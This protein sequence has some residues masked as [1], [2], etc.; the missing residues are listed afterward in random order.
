MTKAEIEL[1]E[2]T[3]ENVGQ[4]LRLSVADDQ[5]CFVA[6][7]A[8]SLAQA[9]VYP[10]CAWP[11]AIYAG[12]A[13]VGFLMLEILKPDH[14]KAPDGRASY[15]LWRL[16][17]GSGHQHNGYGTAAVRAAIA[18]VRGLPDA[19]ALKTSYVPDKPGS[20]GPFYL[21]LGFVPTGKVD[22]DGEIELSLEL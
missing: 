7:N 9:Y 15:F 6:T 20:P 4:V 1:R 17:I 8:V 5:A 14:P 11:R 19:H 12:D 10:E 18:F 21:G 13:L 22:E 3:S 2:I 16:M